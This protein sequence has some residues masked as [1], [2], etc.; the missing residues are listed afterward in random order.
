MLIAVALALLVTAP[1]SL[2]EFSPFLR[3]PD[4]VESFEVVQKT[5]IKFEILPTPQ[6]VS[7]AMAS[8]LAASILDPKSFDNNGG[9]ACGFQPGVAFR[10]WKGDK[11]VDVLICFRCSE[12]LVRPA[13]S[14][15]WGTG[16]LG[17]DRAAQRFLSL[18]KR[19]R[20][21]DPN[22]KDLK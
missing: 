22:L 4:K 9:K 1:L 16:K 20:P 8:E 13:D 10:F 17:F 2:K 14:N 15:G 18:A 21:E 19:A 12:L 5:P 7:A 3:R 6:P 11:A